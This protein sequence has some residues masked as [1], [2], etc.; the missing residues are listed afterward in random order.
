M[1]VIL[2]SCRQFPAGRHDADVDHY[3]VYFTDYIEYFLCCVL[4]IN[5]LS[6]SVSCVSTIASG[7]RSELSIHDCPLGFH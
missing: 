1:T 6:S 2:F 3:T 7:S 5:C 4:F